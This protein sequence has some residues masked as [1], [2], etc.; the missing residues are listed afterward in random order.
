MYA[1]LIACYTFIYV[2]LCT[3]IKRGSLQPNCKRNR[4]PPE[5]TGRSKIFS[6]SLSNRVSTITINN[7]II[8]ARRGRLL[9][10]ACNGILLR[11]I[12][13]LRRRDNYCLP[14]YKLGPLCEFVAWSVVIIRAVSRVRAVQRGP[15]GVRPPPPL[16]PLPPLSLSLSFSSLWMSPT[17]KNIKLC[18]QCNWNAVLC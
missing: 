17:F 12:R 16:P 15:R 2:Y 8:R 3:G 7:N 14:P 9:W 11:D 4:P 13:D 10:R 6:F 18:T 5:S 1:I